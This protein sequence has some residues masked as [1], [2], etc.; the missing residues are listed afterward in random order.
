MLLFFLQYILKTG[1]VTRPPDTVGKLYRGKN[2]LTFTGVFS[3]SIENTVRISET[4]DCTSGTVLSD[5]TR[6]GEEGV[7][8]LI[9]SDIILPTNSGYLCWCPRDTN[10]CTNGAAL[11][12]S[13][14]GPTMEVNL[15]STVGVQFK[16][17]LEGEELT[18]TDRILFTE[19]ECGSER[20]QYG[21]LVLEKPSMRFGQSYSVYVTTLDPLNICWCPGTR[22]CEE[23][24]MYTVP[25][26]KVSAIGPSFGHHIDVTAGEEFSVVLTTEIASSGDFIR[27]TKNGKCGPDNDSAVANAICNTD[28][29]R[30]VNDGVPDTYDETSETWN[31]F[32]IEE[33]GDFSICWCQDETF[34]P[35]TYDTVTAACG[36]RTVSAFSVVVGT[37]S[38]TGL[39]YQ[40][41]ECD[42]WKECFIEA[43]TPK[44]GIALIGLDRDC[45]DARYLDDDELHQYKDGGFTVSSLPPD[46]FK[47]CFCMFEIVGYCDHGSAYRMVLGSLEL[48]GPPVGPKESF[49]CDKSECKIE[50]KGSGFRTQD[51]VAYGASCPTDPSNTLFTMSGLFADGAKY[52]NVGPLVPGF[53]KL[54]LCVADGDHTCEWFSYEM[55]SVLV[56]DAVMEPEEP[57]CRH[58]LVCQ[59]NIRTPT[60]LHNGDQVWIDAEGFGNQPF[61]IGGLPSDE[62]IFTFTIETGI[63]EAT[64]EKHSVY[65]CSNYGQRYGHEPGICTRDTFTLIGFV[66]VKTS[67]NSI[68]VTRPTMDILTVDLDSPS[69]EGGLF[70]AVSAIPAPVVPLATWINYLQFDEPVGKG[71]KIASSKGLNQVHVPLTHQENIPE[72]RKVH[73]WCFRDYECEHNKCAM[74]H[75]PEGFVTWLDPSPTIANVQTTAG[76]DL[77]IHVN[78]PIIESKAR[79]RLVTNGIQLPWMDCIGNI[80]TCT[81]VTKYEE[82]GQFTIEF[83]DRWFRDECKYA[84]PKAQATVMGVYRESLVMPSVIK[85][86]SI[87]YVELHGFGM[88][89]LQDFRSCNGD[90]HSEVELVHSNFTHSLWELKAGEQGTE[91]RLC[92]FLPSRLVEGTL[93]S[94][95]EYVDCR[96]GDWYNASPCSATCGKGV[97]LIRRNVTTRRV[98]RGKPCPVLEQEQKCGV[99]CPSLKLKNAQLIA[100]EK[101]FV[102]EPFQIAV[103]A[104]NTETGDRLILTTRSQICGRLARIVTGSQCNSTRT[105]QVMCGD[106]VMGIKVPTRGRYR[107]CF[108][109][110]SQEHGC[111]DSSAYD[112]DLEIN[113]EVEERP[114]IEPMWYEDLK[115]VAMIF[116]PI[117]GGLFLM[118][119]L[120]CIVR[121]RKK[122]FEKFI[123]PQE[124][125]DEG[126][127][128]AADVL[129]EVW[130]SYNRLDHW[131]AGKQNKDFLTMP[132][133]TSKNPERNHR[134]TSQGGWTVSTSTSSKDSQSNDSLKLDVDDNSSSALSDVSS[135]MKSEPDIEKVSNPRPK[136]RQKRKKKKKSERSSR[137]VGATLSFPKAVDAP[138][139]VAPFYFDGCDTPAD[140]IP[141]GDF[142]TDHIL[143]AAARKLSR[144]PVDSDSDNEKKDPLITGENQSTA[145]MED[146]TNTDQDL[147][148]HKDSDKQQESSKNTEDPGSELKKKEDDPNSASSLK[149][150]N[151]DVPDTV[152]DAVSLEAA[153]HKV[154]TSDSK[155]ESV[156]DD[157]DVSDAS[158]KKDE[159]ATAD[160][161]DGDSKINEASGSEPS[162]LIDLDISNE[163]VEPT[164]ESSQ[165]APKA[166]PKS[167]QARG[168]G[169][170]RGYGMF[171][172]IA[173]QAP[174]GL[175]PRPNKVTTNATMGRLVEPPP[176]QPKDERFEMDAAPPTSLPDIFNMSFT[177]EVPLFPSPGAPP[178]EPTGKDIISDGTVPV[179]PNAGPPP[180]EPTEKV[181]V[182]EKETVSEEPKVDN[183]TGIPSFPSV[184][185][186]PVAP[187]DKVLPESIGTESVSTDPDK[188]VTSSPE[189][190]DTEKVVP[191]PPNN[192]IFQN[193]YETPPDTPQ[194]PKFVPKAPIVPKL[195]LD[196]NLQK[197]KKSKNLVPPPPNISKGK[198]EENLPSSLPVPPSTKGVNLPNPKVSFASFARPKI[199]TLSKE[200][201]WPFK[202]KEMHVPQVP[203][204]APIVEPVQQR[205]SSPKAKPVLETTDLEDT[206]ESQSSSVPGSTINRSFSLAKSAG[207][208][209]KGGKKKEKVLAQ[210]NTELQHCRKPRQY[211]SASDLRAKA[212]GSAA[213]KENK[214][215]ARK[216]NKNYVE[217]DSD[218]GTASSD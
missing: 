213:M 176:F 196:L 59:I 197:E 33:T 66:D 199:P 105:G 206:L 173:K 27:I 3:S 135:E 175:P 110:F 84:I 174:G 186:P 80:T 139:D 76:D 191:L 53:Y 208:K 101:L 34:N 52:T 181:L 127:T 177:S 43:G 94:V 124:V 161:L 73:V 150:E 198:Q 12:Y 179:F 47:I 8:T 130:K 141:F 61:M 69:K 1:A 20:S 192:G 106:G 11:P 88:D 35:Q 54:C 31:R 39:E 72:N 93:F 7:D 115:F 117:G 13:L 70:C 187:T 217:S 185:P 136:S 107:T 201:K 56:V 15:S 148:D 30:Y 45:S 98:G 131:N 96:V 71:M 155:K 162:K 74:P 167:P 129:K 37:I 152:V 122:K 193:L 140:D 41:F 17:D 65:F 114:I 189:P 46:V 42:A 133:E 67:L 215:S 38:V 21:F 194:K 171:K 158:P 144:H 132:L 154:D 44:D 78:G 180:A 24:A 184:G 48:K 151:N 89:Q 214:R 62:S 119:I 209:V 97:L 153:P 190:L 113:I 168:N 160:K 147:L 83:C 216:T 104:E 90:G 18:D 200:G 145:K 82:P 64:M 195:S 77:I 210:G 118:I 14:I 81:T 32:M 204:P 25:V 6:F 172:K 126:T 182:P 169:L 75:T 188:K 100:P 40:L 212:S 170:L 23:D 211:V 57:V 2:D 159:E 134:A 111:T 125:E 36:A 165:K 112:V 10:P 92:F 86:D 26:G 218:S 164:T 109:D 128:V 137:N 9:F 103:N 102:D 207:I 5:G 123:A 51:T 143:K 202:P 58:G 55:G 49:N 4:D 99:P 121:R 138:D 85:P 120:W 29:C 146:K 22:G 149:N 91:D 63:I 68:L 203:V 163:K 16:I 116:G 50:V 157:Q 108:C 142:Q 60:R 19:T 205:V 87:N 79:V 95:E 28:G 183:G 166:K 178:N 156:T